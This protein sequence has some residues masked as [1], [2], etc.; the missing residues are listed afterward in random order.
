MNYALKISNVHVSYQDR[1]NRF[2]AL[3]DVTF[4][5]PK[6]EFVTIIGPSGCGK[7]TLLYAIA[8]LKKYQKGKIVVKG[9]NID[10]PLKKI[11]V[12]FQDPL[13]LPWRTVEQ[14]I[15]FGM[16][17]QKKKKEEIRKKIKDLISLVSL[18]GFENY[19]PGQLSGGMKQKVNLA[20]ALATDPDI[21]LLDE[22]FAHIDEQS[23]EEMQEILLQIYQKT[24][25]TLIFV[26]HNIEEAIFIGSRIVVISK[27]PGTVVKEIAIPFKRPRDLSIKEHQSFAKIKRSIRELLSYGQN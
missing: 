11:G 27:S 9:E 15:S 16:E 24:K 17:I 2:L 26:T 4:S 23:R 19:Y 12:V 18:N 5:V 20:R 6:G 13:L 1:T 8:G 14:N 3:K 25:K 10:S 7:T 22:P 21:L